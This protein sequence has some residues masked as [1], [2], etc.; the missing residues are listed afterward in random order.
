MYLAIQLK[1]V[2]VLFNQKANHTA[3]TTCKL[4]AWKNQGQK[5]TLHN[6]LMPFCNHNGTILSIQK[7]NQ[8]QQN[9]SAYRII[10]LTY[11][12]NG[13]KSRINRHQ[14]TV[15]FFQKDFLHVSTFC[16][17]FSCNSMS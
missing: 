16:T 13:F 7:K 1:G 10:S 14:L 12:L 8:I 9:D 17:S 4:P 15:G 5:H 3:M 11:D 6:H 2:L